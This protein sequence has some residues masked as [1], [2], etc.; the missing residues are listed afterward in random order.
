MSYNN[1]GDSASY[2]SNNSDRWLLLRHHH[3][4]TQIKK[5]IKKTLLSGKEGSCNPN[6]ERILEDR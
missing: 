3:W 4:K 2:V 1:D 6:Q 5:F